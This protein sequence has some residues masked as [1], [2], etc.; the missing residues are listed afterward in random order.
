LVICA[1]GD[2]VIV[3]ICTW[4]FDPEQLP[5]FGDI[6]RTVAISEE[7]VVADAMLAT[8]EHIDQEPAHELGHCQRH[9]GVATGAFDAVILDAKGDVISI[10]SDLAAKRSYVNQLWRRQRPHQPP[11]QGKPW[12]PHPIDGFQPK[13]PLRC[14]RS[15]R[16]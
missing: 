4:R 3:L 6:G 2:V 1:P 8:W 15:E 14:F 10:G 7:A 5:D 13:C 11:K 9:G 16:I 12:Q